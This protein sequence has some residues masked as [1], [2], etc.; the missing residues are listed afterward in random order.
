MIYALYLHEHFQPLTASA[1]THMSK[2]YLLSS[3]FCIFSVITLPAVAVYG[4]TVSGRWDA[5][6]KLEAKGDYVNA[7][8]LYEQALAAARKLDFKGLEKKDMETLRD[9]ATSGSEAR[10]AGARA[11]M[12]ALKSDNSRIGR[13]TATSKSQEAF[14]NAFEEMD[15]KRPDLVNACP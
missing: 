13:R 3:L 15:R 7:V 12:V 2:P 4:P 6:S 14:R 8:R 10:L 1:S 11:G 9:C 5:G